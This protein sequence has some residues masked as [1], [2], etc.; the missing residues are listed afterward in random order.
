MQKITPFLWFNDN[1]EEASLISL[2]TSNKNSKA[3]NLVNLMKPLRKKN[4]FTLRYMGSNDIFDQFIV[5]KNL[6]NSGSPF[7][8]RNSAAHI[9]SQ[10]F[11]VA[12]AG[13]PCLGWLCAATRKAAFLQ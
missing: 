9:F 7:F 3:E 6:S 2:S 11:S 8:I 12:S 5:S 1:A 13:H 4:E 10:C